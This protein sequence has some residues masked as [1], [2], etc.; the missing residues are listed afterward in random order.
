MFTFGKSR[1]DEQLEISRRK[2]VRAQVEM[3]EAEREKT[4]KMERLRIL[5][6]AKE[7]ADKVKNG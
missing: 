6:L 7:A 1:A 5:R 4:S 2:A 3:D